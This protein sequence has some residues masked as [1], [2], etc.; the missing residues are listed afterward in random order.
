MFLISSSSFYGG[1]GDG[2]M[3]APRVQKIQSE[4]VPEFEFQGWGRSGAFGGL[5]GLPG[6]SLGRSLG[7]RGSF[8]GAFWCP[9]DPFGMDFD[10]LGRL[11]GPLGSNFFDFFSAVVADSPKRFA[12]FKKHLFQRSRCINVG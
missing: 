2:L 9:G 5:V 3:V 12:I 10:P 7:S 6:S 1:G 8:W 4:C 11:S